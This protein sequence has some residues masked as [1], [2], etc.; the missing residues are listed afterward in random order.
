MLIST[1]INQSNICDS[2]VRKWCLHYIQWDGSRLNVILLVKSEQFY[3]FFFFFF[4]FFLSFF[5]FWDELQII[6][7]YLLQNCISI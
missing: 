1:Y 2:L 5:I 4:F 3:Q 7:F 6:N